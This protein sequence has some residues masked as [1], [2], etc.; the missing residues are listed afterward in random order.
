M[1]SWGPRSLPGSSDYI[2]GGAEPDWGGQKQEDQMHLESLGRDPQQR[3]CK[4]LARRGQHGLVA[5]KSGVA[6]SGG[7]SRWPCQGRR[8][9][10]TISSTLRECA[11][12]S[13]RTNSTKQQATAGRC[14]AAR[15][16]ES[17]SGSAPPHGHVHGRLRPCT[18]HSVPEIPADSA[19]ATSEDPEPRRSV[20][21]SGS[22]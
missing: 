10:P 2:F 9:S 19:T 18:A 7:S 21:E 16:R 5:G 15:I 11:P 3:L 20:G 8:H 6:T 13:P 14:M 4:E 22:V 17:G 12:Q 1:S